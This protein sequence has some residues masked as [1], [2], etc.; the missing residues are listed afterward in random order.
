MGYSIWFNEYKPF[1]VLQLVWPDKSN[2]FPWEKDFDTSYSI[3][4]PMLNK[5]LDFK[6]FTNPSL[7]VVTV[8]EFLDGMKPINYVAHTTDAA[9]QFLTAHNVPQEDIRF[10]SISSIVKLDPTLNELFDLD[11]GECAERDEDG[12]WIRASL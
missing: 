4:Q 2:S 7:A 12:D 10:I 1:D 11:R 6:F 8:K 5:E 3:Q 9:W